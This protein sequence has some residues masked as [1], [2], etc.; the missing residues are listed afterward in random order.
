MVLIFWCF[1]NF[2]GKEQGI[3]LNPVIFYK[4]DTNLFLESLFLDIS[5]HQGLHH[6]YTPLIIGILY[7]IDILGQA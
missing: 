1:G 4:M 3:Y 7:C 6:Y 5:S 2:H